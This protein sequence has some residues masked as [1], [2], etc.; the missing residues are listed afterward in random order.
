LTAEK[1]LLQVALADPDATVDSLR[2]TCRDL[3]ELG[4]AQERLIH[5]LLTLAVGE[6]GVERRRPVD[7]ASVAASVV[8]ARE[9]L[10][11]RKAITVRTIL[12]AAATAGDPGL[13]ESLT[14]NL[15]ENALRHNH[16]GGWVEVVTD[17][18]AGAA[19]LTVRNS[20]P[21]VP[22]ERV[23][24]LFEPFT[25][26]SGPRLASHEGHGLGLAIVSAIARAHGARLIPS[27]PP[28]GGL[29]I[30][31]SFPTSPV[32]HEVTVMLDGDVS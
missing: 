4:E 12:G 22:P 6:Q 13:V 5:S 20:G 29:E 19:R 15:V 24:Q 21:V 26:L 10:A 11:R 8:S 30:T 14:A 17:T 32:D 23:E 27:A 1:A 25:R 3:L 2:A 7:L 31:A 18:V 28:G 16:T 9:D